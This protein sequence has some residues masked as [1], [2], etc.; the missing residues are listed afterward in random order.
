MEVYGC[1]YISQDN[2]VYN[3]SNQYT[4][5]GSIGYSPASNLWN[6]Y[7]DPNTLTATYSLD[8]NSGKESTLTLGGYQTDLLDQPS[9]VISSDC[10]YG[11]AYDDFGF[12]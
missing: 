12:G 7:V 4:S 1:D 8:L 6:Q 5:Y 10:Q 11:Y 2:W 3:V 9:L